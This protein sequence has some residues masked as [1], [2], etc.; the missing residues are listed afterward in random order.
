MEK[1]YARRTG[2]RKTPCKNSA[3]KQPLIQNHFFV[4]NK[5]LDRRTLVVEIIFG[6][7]T[8]FDVLPF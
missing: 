4:Q 8:F 6:R 2:L 5:V 1:D 3:S 7:V